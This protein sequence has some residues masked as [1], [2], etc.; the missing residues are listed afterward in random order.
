[1]AIFSGGPG[2]QELKKI[3]GLATDGLSGVEDSLAYRVEELEQH[4]HSAERWY[5]SDGD[6]TASTANNLTPFELEAGTDGAY[7]TEILLFAAN[8]ISGSD[9]TGTP[10]KYDAHRLEVTGSSAN[11]IYILQFYCGLTDFASAELCT[12]V[13]YSKSTAAGALVPVN[14]QMGRQVVANKLWGRV[15]SETNGATIEFLMGIHAYNG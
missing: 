10:V 2:G 6:N 13:P 7:G 1:M 3:D 12:E 14:V 15:K 4:F 8:D 9:F 11:A 5:G